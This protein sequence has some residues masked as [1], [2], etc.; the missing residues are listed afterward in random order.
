MTNKGNEDVQECLK[1][2]QINFHDN[3]LVD[4]LE[5]VEGNKT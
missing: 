2:L 5:K 3:L 4:N 1:D